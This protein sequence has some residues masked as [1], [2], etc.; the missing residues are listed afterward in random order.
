MNYRKL[1]SNH[2][3]I[4]I[5]KKY[6]IHHIDLNHENNSIE[7]LMILPA[8]LHKRYHFLKNIVTSRQFPVQIS[9]SSM[10]SKSYYLDASKKFIETLEQCNKWYDYKLYLDGAMPNIHSFSIYHV[11]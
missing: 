5:P 10:G 2:Y 7:N 11:G 1:F 9:G 6:D 4:E 3:G 8:A